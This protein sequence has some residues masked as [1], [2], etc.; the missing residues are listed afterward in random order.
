MTPSQISMLSSHKDQVV[1]LP[2]EA[3]VFMSNDFC[4]VAGYTMG[5]QVLSLQGH[6]EFVA[7][8]ASDLMDMRA[9]LIG[10]AVYQAGKQ[11]LEKP[12]QSREVA[13][14]I[15]NFIQGQPLG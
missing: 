2:E 13:R 11:S 15:L 9:D 14:W 10:D 3:E 1:E 4:P 6:P 7:A 8:Y 5:A 12:T